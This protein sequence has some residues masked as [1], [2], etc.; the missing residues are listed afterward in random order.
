MRAEREVQT[1]LLSHLHTGDQSVSEFGFGKLQKLS[2][3]QFWRGFWRC[4]TIQQAALSI[5]AL[6]RWAQTPF[7]G[8]TFQLHVS[9]NSFILSLL[10]DIMKHRHCQSSKMFPLIPTPH[11]LQK[12]LFISHTEEGLDRSCLSLWPLFCS[13][14]TPFIQSGCVC[15]WE[16]TCECVTVD[17]EH[18]SV[19]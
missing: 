1:R 19:Q 4:S 3:P 10:H 11:E 18:Q 9:A 15:V 17:S 8:K 12:E 5:L 13:L 14:S 6:Y 2:P 16:C 7:K